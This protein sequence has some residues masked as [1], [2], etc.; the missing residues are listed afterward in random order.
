MLKTSL[1]PGSPLSTTVT[2]KLVATAPL[3]L[4][5]PPIVARFQLLLIEVIW[6][7]LKVNPAEL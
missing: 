7:D 4:P 3:M 2:V 1:V 6:V 5:C